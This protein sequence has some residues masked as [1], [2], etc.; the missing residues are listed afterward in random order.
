MTWGLLAI[1]TSFSSIQNSGYYSRFQ[2]FLSGKYHCPVT[3]KVFNAHTH[4]VAVKPTGN[5]YCY[6]VSNLM[7]K[8]WNVW[9]VPG[10]VLAICVAEEISYSKP[11]PFISVK[12]LT[13]PALGLT[14]PQS[15]YQIKCFP[16]VQFN[17]MM[18]FKLI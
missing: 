4:I 5:V 7:H 9:E 8:I 16:T 18:R 12:I 10:I 15:A 3:Y 6:D 11:F 14:I 1:K 13:H 2:Y 17:S